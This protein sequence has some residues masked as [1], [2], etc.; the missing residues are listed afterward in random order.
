MKVEDCPGYSNFLH[1]FEHP[2]LIV[3]YFGKEMLKT[4]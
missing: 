3:Y 2:F 4:M 1:P